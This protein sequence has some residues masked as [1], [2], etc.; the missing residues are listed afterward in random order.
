MFLTWYRIVTLKHVW[1]AEN[2][3][4]ELHEVSPV[5]SQTGSVDDTLTLYVT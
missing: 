3:S 1:P 5:G 4:V 2:Y